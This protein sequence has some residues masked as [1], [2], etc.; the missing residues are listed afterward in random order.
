MAQNHGFSNIN[1]D[2][3]FGI[4]YQTMGDWIDTIT[5]VLSYQIPH[6]SCYSL[7]VEEDTP[8]GRMKREGR[9]QDPDEELERKMYSKAIEVFE[10]P[11]WSSMKSQIWRNLNTVADII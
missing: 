5:K 2:I 4:P 10:K 7:T 6:V 1:A 3:I 11:V 9:W 8:F